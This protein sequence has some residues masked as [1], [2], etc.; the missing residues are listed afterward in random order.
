AAPFGGTNFQ[1][2]NGMAL[3]ISGFV[4]VAGSTTSGDFPTTTGSYQS[5]IE[6]GYDGFIA[7]IDLSS[8]S[9]PGLALATACIVNA[10]NYLNVAVGSGP[11]GLVAPGEIISIFGNGLGPENP[12]GTVLDS[13][14]HIATSVAG[15]SL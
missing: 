13:S 15:V 5:R 2:F 7:R 4:Y 8:S 1:W 14:G 12:A 6:G 10:A 11:S 9:K 3:D